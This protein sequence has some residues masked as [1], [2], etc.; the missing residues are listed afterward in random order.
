MAWFPQIVISSPTTIAHDAITQYR[1]D[2]LSV[3]SF[4]IECEGRVYFP[5]QEGTFSYIT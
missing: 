4:E 1:P 5:G 2:E 3:P